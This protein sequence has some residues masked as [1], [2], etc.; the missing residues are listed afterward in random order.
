MTD[1]VVVRRAENGWIVMAFVEGAVSTTVQADA[2][3]ALWDVVE[4]LDMPV[5]RTNDHG[6]R[7]VLLC[8]YVRRGD[9]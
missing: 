9:T 3:D 7:E 5:D 8:H 1:E 2:D 4:A 6:E